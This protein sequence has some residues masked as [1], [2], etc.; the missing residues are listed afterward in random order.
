MF[1]IWWFLTKNSKVQILPI[2]IYLAFS[3]DKKKTLIET[4]QATSILYA[5]VSTDIDRES[6]SDWKHLFHPEILFRWLATRLIFQK[7]VKKNKINLKMGLFA[8]LKGRVRKLSIILSY[9]D[10]VKLPLYRGAVYLYL[11]CQQD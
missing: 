7:G 11:E 2:F 4:K 3:K 8:R 6:R 9:L 10:F 1:I 5:W